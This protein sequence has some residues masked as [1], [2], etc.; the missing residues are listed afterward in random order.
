MVPG[1]LKRGRIESAKLIDGSF[2]LINVAAVGRI[3]PLLLPL[4][5]SDVPKILD[6]IAQAAF[7]LSVIL[8][9]LATIYLAIN[10]WQTV[11]GM[12]AQ[13]ELNSMTG[14]IWYRQKSQPAYFHFDLRGR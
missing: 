10:L 3:V 2:W 1:F 8:G 4:M 5:L 11:Y 12:P 14:G 6:T 9:L 7:G 13:K